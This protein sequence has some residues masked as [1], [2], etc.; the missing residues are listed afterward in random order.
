MVAAEVLFA[1]EKLVLVRAGERSV[2]LPWPQSHVRKG[3]VL[4][5]GV[6]VHGQAKLVVFTEPTGAV[7]V[8]DFD[9]TASGM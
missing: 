5:V 3:D 2:T 1:G 6:T 7:R 9:A 8:I 4:S